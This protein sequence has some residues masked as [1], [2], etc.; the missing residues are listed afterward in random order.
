MNITDMINVPVSSHKYEIFNLNALPKIMLCT[1]VKNQYDERRL[2]IKSAYNPKFVT[3][4]QTIND[5]LQ[6]Y[7]YY[8]IC[9]ELKKPYVEMINQIIDL[10]LFSSKTEYTRKLLEYNSILH[11]YDLT[12]DECFGY[13]SDGILP[14]DIKHLN[15]ITKNDFSSIVSSGFEE[16]INGDIRKKPVYSRVLNFN[17]LVLTKA[18]GYD[19]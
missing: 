6:P 14:I 4:F 8:G 10:N 16:L 19:G 11:E 17:I 18:N 15:K 5:E 1:Y 7:Y 2:S 13:F 3:H 9:I 12:C